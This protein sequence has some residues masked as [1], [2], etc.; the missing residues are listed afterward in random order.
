MEKKINNETERVVRYFTG[1][2][3]GRHVAE[4]S[5]LVSK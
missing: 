1:L 5:W 3:L 2:G 4:Q